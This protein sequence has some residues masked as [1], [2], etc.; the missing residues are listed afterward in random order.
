PRRDEFLKFVRMHH[1]KHASC[2]P[3]D[4]QV[5][6]IEDVTPWIGIRELALRFIGL[7]I[8]LGVFELVHPWVRREDENHDEMLKRLHRENGARFRLKTP[9]VSTVDS[10]SSRAVARFRRAENTTPIVITSSAELAW[11]ALPSISSAS[12]VRPRSWG[13][14]TRRLASAES[15][16]TGR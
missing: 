8:I 12:S 4:G 6:G 13:K 14:C 16:P 11:A 9:V 15:W 7:G 2:D 1:E 3:L 5:R 10:L